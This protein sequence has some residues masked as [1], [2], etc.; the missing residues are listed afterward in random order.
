V[1]HDERNG[2]IPLKKNLQANNAGIG[3]IDSIDY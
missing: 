3:I 1:A 2:G